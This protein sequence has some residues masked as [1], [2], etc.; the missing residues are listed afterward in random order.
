MRHR[1]LGFDG[2]CVMAEVRLGKDIHVDVVGVHLPAG[3]C[4]SEARLQIL[5]RIQKFGVGGSL[6]LLGDFNVRPGEEDDV[7]AL[8]GFL[9]AKYV[10][11]S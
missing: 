8:F 3:E 1:P 6:L 7:T 9:E 11:H 2:P 4:G 10:G 5:R